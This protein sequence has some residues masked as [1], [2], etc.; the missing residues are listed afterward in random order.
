[1]EEYCQ[2][3]PNLQVVRNDVYAR[4]CHSAYNKGTALAELAR[5]LNITASETLAAGD[6]LNDLPMLSE[7]YAKFLVAPLNA[8]GVVKQTVRAQNGFVSD[9]PQGHGIAEGIKFHLSQT[10]VS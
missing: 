9:L 5:R 7:R 2:E 6:H 10:G 8:I 1:M 4:F 3:V